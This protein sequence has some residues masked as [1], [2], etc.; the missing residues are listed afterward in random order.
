MEEVWV[1]D[2]GFVRDTRAIGI[3]DAGNVVVNDLVFQRS[4]ETDT[5]WFRPLVGTKKLIRELDISGLEGAEAQAIAP[6][7]TIVGAPAPSAVVTLTG[8]TVT[9]PSALVW[10]RKGIRTTFEPAPS[11]SGTPAAVNSDGV[12]IGTL[13]SKDRGIEAYYGLPGDT[14]VLKTANF[15]SLAGI[16]EDGQAAGTVRPGYGSPKPY[17][18]GVVFERH[19]LKSI[20]ATAPNII[21]AISPNG[22]YIVGRIG[23]ANNLTGGTLAWLSTTSP[24]K[25]INNPG[26]MIVRDVSDRGEIVGSNRGHATLWSKGQL[27]DL[28][29]KVSEAHRYWLMREA[30]GINAAGEI[31]VQARP[32]GGTGVLTALKLTPR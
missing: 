19:S 24:P 21:D 14:K 22:R 12:V 10:S 15:L 31:A 17:L 18:T 2:Y 23:V 8:G 7:G 1:S 32:P 26:L 30:V 20:N 3:D 25:P 9:S 5:P 13:T 6:N 29:Y 4:S 27:I 28:N 11:R 16:T